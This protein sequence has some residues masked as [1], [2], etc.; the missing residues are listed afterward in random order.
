MSRSQSSN[1]RHQAGRGLRFRDAF[2]RPSRLS[3]CEADGGDTCGVTRGGNECVVAPFLGCLS[4]FL[5]RE[6]AVRRS[7]SSCSLS[8][9]LSL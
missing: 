7:G 2:L 4:G 8:L 6:F 1:V 5:Q 3:V 9:S